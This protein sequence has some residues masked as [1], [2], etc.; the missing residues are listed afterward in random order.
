MMKKLL[1]PAFLL[2]LWGCTAPKAWYNKSVQGWEDTAAP[3]ATPTYSL[4]LVGDAGNPAVGGEPTLLLLQKQLQAA[5]E[6]AGVTFLGDNIYPEGMPRKEDDDRAE[7]ERR[8]A[9]QVKVVQ[10]FSGDVVIVP[11]N[12]DW[13]Q[14][15]KYG[16]KNVKRQEKF[17]EKL[18]EGR[19]VWLPSDGCPGPVEVPLAKDVMLIAIDTQWWLHKYEK[20]DHEHDCEVKYNAD[21]LEMLHDAIERNKEKKIIIAGHHPLYSYGAHGGH[22]PPA[23]HLF[24][25]MMAKENL[26]VPLPVLGTFGVVFRKVWGNIQDIPHPVYQELKEELT[27]IFDHYPNIIYASGHDHNL[28]YLPVDGHHYIVSGAGVK[29]RYVG[30]GKKAHFTYAHKGFT[31]LDFHANGDVVMQ[32]IVAEEETGNAKVVYRETI[33]NKPAPP[34]DEQATGP[35]VVYGDSSVTIFADDRYEKGGLFKALFGENYRKEWGTEIKVPIIDIWARGLKI[36]K[37]G[38]GHQTKS[39]RLEDENGRHFVLRSV[40][41]YPELATPEVLRGTF[42]G[43]IVQDQI[44]ASHPYAAFTVPKL[45][46]AAGVYHT[47]PQ[48]VYLPDDPRLGDYREDFGGTLYLFEERPAGDRSDI[49]SFGRSKKIISTLKMVEKFQEDNHHMADDQACLRARLFDQWLGDWD[50]HDDQ[51][52][53]ARFKEGDVSLYRPIP[54]DRDVPFFR[55]EGFFAWLALRKWGLRDVQEFDPHV[56]D[57]QGYGL[58]ARY[59]DRY[60]LTELTREDWINAATTMQAALTD[61]LIDEAVS[62]WPEEI[63]EV[64]GAQ[65]AA[66]LK[67]RRD[68]MVKNAETFYKWLAKSVDVLGSDQNEVFQVDRLSD[69]STRVRMWNRKKGGKKGKKLYDR[70]FLRKET[71]EIKLWGMDGKDEFKVKGETKKGIKIRIIG[72]GGQ[73][74]LED[75]SKV[76]GLERKT[77]Y[78]DRKDKKNEIEGG[79]EYRNMM[80]NKREVNDYNRR[81]FEFNRTGPLVGGGFNVDDGIFIGPGVSFLKH[82]FRKAPY[83]LKESL[84]ASYAFRTNAFNIRFKGEYPRAVW[85]WDFVA[86][87]AINAPNYVNWFFGLGNETIIINPDDRQYHRVR[88]E[89]LYAKPQIRKTFLNDQMNF[90]IGALVEYTTVE[91]TEDRF[92]S[93]IAS[94]E[95]DSTG[96][97]NGLL[98]AGGVTGFELDTRDSD[99]IPTRGVH[100]QVD[101]GLHKSLSEEAGSYGNIRSQLSLYVKFHIPFETVLAARVGVGHN[102][103]DFQFF[104]AQQLDGLKNL[105]GYRRTRFSGRSMF[106][107]NTE[108]RIKLFEFKSILFPGKFGIMG[109]NDFGKVYVRDRQS[110]VMHW[111]YGGGFWIAPFNSFVLTGNYTRSVEGWLPYITFGFIF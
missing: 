22:F 37:R 10:G 51:W 69:D 77:L 67:T 2:I 50:R 36:A 105:R 104:Q 97:F 90:S 45:A 92:I 100:F 42:A 101:G 89:Q 24:P 73:D 82:G 102:T 44:S 33:F 64:S 48:L 110:D 5:G 7:S 13:A 46:D 66:A 55:P 14:G 68:D 43:E 41:K 85:G 80:S 23:T 31:R 98:Y 75:E 11:G 26:Y 53:W 61:E 20:P 21:F 56:R 57:V 49:E 47:N 32:F 62:V 29:T 95:L 4:F 25:L 54:R 34:E 78:Y 60:F 88:Y 79:S 96:V 18:M 15:R 63:Y 8:I 84:T 39:M 9:D 87:A 12:H 81:W 3:A 99:V 52:R 71:K 76:A 93:D 109:L 38:G 30:H 35:A 91:R 19:D 74:K 106:Y 72:G 65:I 70:V 40:K 107:Q 103:G 59:W 16:F 17:V 27:E 83:A 108:L 86:D 58:A 6:N 111:G 1:Y 94:V 28:Q